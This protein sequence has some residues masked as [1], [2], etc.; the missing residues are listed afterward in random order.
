MHSIEFSMPRASRRYAW[1]ARSRPRRKMQSSCPK[2]TAQQS[3]STRSSP[4]HLMMFTQW[5]LRSGR[6]QLG[7]QRDRE[8]E[9]ATHAVEE[10]HAGFATSPARHRCTPS[11]SSTPSNSKSSSTHLRRAAQGPVTPM[12]WHLARRIG[13]AWPR[14]RL[15][16]RPARSAASNGRH[17]VSFSYAFD[18]FPGLRRSLTISYQFLF[19]LFQSDRATRSPSRARFCRVLVREDD[20][21]AAALGP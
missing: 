10:A 20:R 2:S 9:S 8:S 15:R 19:V 11:C 14:S 21:V 1:A 3:A 18:S 16:R 6:G 12:H 5:L 13:P 7:A 4:P 17:A